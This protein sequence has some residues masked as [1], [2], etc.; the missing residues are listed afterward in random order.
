VG[1]EDVAAAKR[2]MRRRFLD[3]RR[4]LDPD[5]VEAAATGL[6]EQAMALPELADAGTVAAYY[7]IDAEPGSLPLLAALLDSG[8]RVLLPVVTEDLDLDWAELPGLDEVTTTGRG[9]REPAGRRLGTEAIGDADVV[10]CPGLAVDVTGARLG[11]GAGCYDRALRRADGA[12]WRCI[13]VYDHEIVEA[14]PVTS[15]DE[16]VDAA[17]T[18]T[19]TLRIS[20]RRRIRT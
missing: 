11:R 1:F 3:A 10:F 13:V 9:L 15:H 12:A 18:P 16:R 8:R 6:A 17:I 14:V 19:R 4:G 20:S 7:S 2:T 5:Q